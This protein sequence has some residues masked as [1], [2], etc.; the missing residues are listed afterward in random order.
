M[1]HLAI[2]ADG[3]RRWAKKEGLP[4]KAGYV[5]G[6][7]IIENCCDWAIKNNIKFLTF[8]CLSTENLKRTKEEI[9]LL[10]NLA[11]QYFDEQS[12]WYINK[13][14]RVIF[15]GRKDRLDRGLIKKGEELEKATKNGDSLTLTICLDYG[16][17]DE[18]VRAIAAGARTEEEITSFLT[19][20][21]PEPDV[22]LRTGG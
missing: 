18:I 8:Y 22:I 7:L 10:V 21:I 9:D 13:K 16:G 20:K 4:K 2:I 14:I 1:N 11:H 3:N 15:S 6:L 12:E 17:R 5:Q 19:K